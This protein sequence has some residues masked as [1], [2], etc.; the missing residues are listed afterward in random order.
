MIA[1]LIKRGIL[2]NAMIDYL[3]H[4][5]LYLSIHFNIEVSIIPYAHNRPKVDDKYTIIIFV[6]TVNPLL[7]S[8]I[9]SPSR[10]K[11]I[12]QVSPPHQPKP[13]R[14]IFLLN[15][16]QTTVHSYLDRLIK[17]IHQY[18]L[19][20]IN[21]S[22]ENINVL[23]RHCPNTKFIHLPFPLIFEP[24]TIK[25]RPVVS[26]LTSHHRKRVGDSLRAPVTNFAGCWGAAR[27]DL[28]RTSKVLVNIHHD[29]LNYRIFESIRC[30]QALEMRT[31]VLSESTVS[32]DSVLLKDFIV[33]APS[34]R[35]STK[36]KEI[37]ENYEVHYEQCF[38]EPRIKV[39]E[40]R[41]RN[42][43]I[44]SITEITGLNMSDK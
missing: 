7:F 34:I 32:R 14:R 16:E 44:K 21:Y 27:D 8:Q 36:L 42:V 43:Y 39:I 20:V 6:Q 13:A 37:L 38:S 23:K 26:L 10:P 28:I 5:K 30:Y 19:P 18:N 40:E 4:V 2:L 24:P 29:S 12:I 25:D 35:L 33:F 41:I 11:R 22:M 3:N 9:K 15:T 31:L 1:F 17:D